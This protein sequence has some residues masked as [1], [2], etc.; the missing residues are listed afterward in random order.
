MSTSFTKEEVKTGFVIILGIVIFSGIFFA[1][2]GQQ[3]FFQKTQEI[4]IHFY[5]IR[6]LKEGDP[7]QIMGMEKGHVTEIQTILVDD[8]KM[9]KKKP[10][11]K[12]VGEFRY[13]HKLTDESLIFVDS[14]LTGTTVLKIEPGTGNPVDNNIV[15]EGARATSFN[16]IGQKAGLLIGRIETFINSLTNKDLTNSIQKNIFNLEDSTKNLKKVISAVNNILVP[17]ENK[18]AS[19][20]SS[21]SDFLMAVG[22]NKKKVSDILTHLASSSKNIDEFL[23]KNKSDIDKITKNLRK[24]SSHIKVASREVKWQPWILLKDP[25]EVEIKE[26]NIYN[27]ALE[28]NEGAESLALAVEQL[29]KLQSRSPQSSKNSNHINKL[30]NDISKSI[31]SLKKAQEDIWASLNVK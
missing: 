26:R 1:I 30:L 17:N 21:A 13:D 4:T 2:S 29:K 3:S 16:E 25:D 8:I 11:V 9:G 18:L 24:T 14:S 19:G 5:D 6:G 20:F 31:K 22:K 23:A 12:V 7:I 27:S 28:F 15:F 10:M